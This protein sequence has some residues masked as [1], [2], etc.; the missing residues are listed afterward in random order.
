MPPV[1]GMRHWGK[2]LSVLPAC[3]HRVV[4]SCWGLGHAM[5]A[6]AARWHCCAPRDGL[7]LP[8]LLLPGRRLPAGS[9]CLGKRGS[10]ACSAPAALLHGGGQGHLAL[11]P[12]T[13]SGPR[14]AAAELSLLPA[15][16]TCPGDRSMVVSRGGAVSRTLLLLVDA[17]AAVG[18]V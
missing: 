6:C 10:C 16:C 8:A 15:C 18:M 2:S 3:M 14:A 7:A 4:C 11:Q 1:L 17:L 9:L 12:H 13:A 5:D